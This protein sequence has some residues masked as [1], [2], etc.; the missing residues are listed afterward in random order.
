[1]VEMEN[2]KLDYD[3]EVLRLKSLVSKT[4]PASKFSLYT[5]PFD[6]SFDYFRRQTLTHRIFVFL[7]L[8]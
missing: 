3:Q 7:F 2:I 8:I 6:S 4:P 1:M 5:L